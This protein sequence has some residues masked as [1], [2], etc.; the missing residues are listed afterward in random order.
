MKFICD[1]SKTQTWFR[2]E[3]ETEAATESQIMGHAVEKYFRNEWERAA[4]TH[5]PASQKVIEQNIGLNAH[6]QR[7]MPLFLTLRDGAGNAL[8]TAMLPPRGIEDGGFRPI[9]V[10]PHNA[11]PYPAHGEAISKLGEY[12][13]LTLDRD[14]CFPYRRA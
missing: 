13:G 7:E 12:F 3:T 9:V 6:I 10:G 1:A 11:D 14:R 8:V 5:Q 2:I 4:R